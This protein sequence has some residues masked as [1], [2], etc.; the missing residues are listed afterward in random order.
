MAG[1]VI[2][3]FEDFAG[4]DELP[5]VALRMGLILRVKLPVGKFCASYSLSTSWPPTHR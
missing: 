2:G 4:H 1:I 5:L 3:H